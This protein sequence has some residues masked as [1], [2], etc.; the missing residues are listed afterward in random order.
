M[1][2]DQ[3]FERVKDSQMLVLDDLGS[4]S[5]TPWAEEK[6]FQLLVH[7]HDNQLTT[8]ITMP[9]TLSISAPLASR[10]GD[11]RGIIVLVEI[12]APDHRNTDI[13]SK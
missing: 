4:Q 8:V 9:R 5:A 11:V 13:R 6:L 2:Y 3:V 12:D 1:S 7:R 10:L